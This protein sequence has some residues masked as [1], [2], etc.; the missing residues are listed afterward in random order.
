LE[1]D[2]AKDRLDPLKNASHISPINL[3]SAQ[4]NYYHARVKE[5]TRYLNASDKMGAVLWER[6]FEFLQELI[7]WIEIMHGILLT[8]YS[9]LY[10]QEQLTA[11]LSETS[12][13]R[14]NTYYTA[15]DEKA[16]VKR[17][18]EIEAYKNR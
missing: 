13:Q 4:T 14:R 2:A 7:N 16:R 8:Q 6:D 18:N 3:L 1:Y 12:I 15:K 5:M 9:L 10:D 17:E 11:A